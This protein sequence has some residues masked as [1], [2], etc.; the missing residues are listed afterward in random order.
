MTTF[1]S[2]YIY[3][4]LRFF[5]VSAL[6]NIPTKY[7]IV[8]R[9]PTPPAITNAATGLCIALIKPPEVHKVISVSQENTNIKYLGIVFF[10][11][12]LSMAGFQTKLERG[13][14]SYSAN[15][16]IMHAGLLSLI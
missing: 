2:Q 3:A 1:S 7:I 12:I 5:I 6:R 4:L 14:F 13:L 16:F 10:K 8:P 11:S 9:I 15:I